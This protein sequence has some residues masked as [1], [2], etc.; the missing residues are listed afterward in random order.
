[1]DLQRPHV[2]LDGKPCAAIGQ[3]GLMSLYDTL[4]GQLDIA[5]SQLLVTDNDFTNPDFR[6][7][8][9]ETVDLLLEHRVVPVFNENDA[10]SIRKAP[11]KLAPL[12]TPS[13]H[14]AAAVTVSSA[15]DP[16]VS[17][18]PQI[19]RSEGTLHLTPLAALLALE[20]RADLLVLLSDVE[21]LY[22]GPPSDPKSQIIHTY[23]KHKHDDEVTFGEKSRVGRGGMTAKVEA[24]WMSASAG[25]PVVIA[26]CPCRKAL[27]PV[28]LLLGWT[29]PAGAR[30]MA[31]AA[32]TASRKLQALASQERQQILRDVAAALEAHEAA[33]VAANEED[34]SAAQVAEGLRAIADMKEPI[35]ETLRCTELTEG[36]T[37]EK[38]TWPIGVLLVIFEARPDA[39]PQLDDVIDLVVPRGSNALVSHI[40]D[41]TKIAVLGHADGVCHVFVDKAADVEMAERLLVDAKVDYPSACNAMV[42]ISTSRI[43]ARGPVGV[44]GLLTTRWLVRGHGQVVDKDK[45]IKYTHKP[46]ALDAFQQT[47]NATANGVH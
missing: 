20:L 37:L 25:L 2:E 22:T 27:H 30:D 43:H 29:A 46:L 24:A 3:S 6:K 34:V 31:V 35:A 28:P 11:Y 13:P 26:R 14:D 16:L 36:L 4:F 32:R 42:G 21:G 40:K 39:L 10:I 17:L 33:I 8:L 19:Q 23:L 44:E 38:Q 9:R 47:A 7:Q 12:P 18:E 1:M 41:N 45:A 5:C 15:C